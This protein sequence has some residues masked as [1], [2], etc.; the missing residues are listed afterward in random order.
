MV[1]L[2]VVVVVEVVEVVVVEL[3]VTEVEVLASGQCNFVTHN[4]NNQFVLMILLTICSY[5]YIS[6]ISLSS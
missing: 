2:V 1:E 5:R 4:R 3:V 6:I